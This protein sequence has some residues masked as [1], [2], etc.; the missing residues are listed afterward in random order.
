MIACEAV[1]DLE[2]TWVIAS[3]VMDDGKRISVIAFDD[4]HDLDANHG[5]WFEVVGDLRR[6]IDLGS[7]S[8]ATFGESW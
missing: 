4:V 2:A 3:D 8:S 1:H 7:R 6:I 5:P